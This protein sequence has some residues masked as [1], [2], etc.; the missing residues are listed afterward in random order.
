MRTTPVL[1]VRSPHSRFR[2]LHLRS[3]A[4][5]PSTPVASRS[6]SQS[7]TPRGHT[8]AA[9]SAPNVVLTAAHCI[10]GRPTALQHL[11]VLV[12][13]PTLRGDLASPDGVRVLGVTAVYVHPKF[14]EATMHYDAALLTLDHSIAGART[15]ALAD[16][17]PL[18]GSTV[19]R[20]P[21]RPCLPSR[22]PRQSGHAK[23]E[24]P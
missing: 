10:T 7:A 24:S 3:S 18:A 4:E 9:P 1:P 23:V 16:S 15:L 22:D 6:S 21:S 2:R 14:S 11:C 12:G 17:S 5:R 19:G 13:S 8:A 20:A